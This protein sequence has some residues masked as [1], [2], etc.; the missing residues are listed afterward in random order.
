MSGQFPRKKLSVA[1]LSRSNHRLTALLAI[2]KGEATTC[3][4]VGIN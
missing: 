3:V 2:V 4:C 1:I